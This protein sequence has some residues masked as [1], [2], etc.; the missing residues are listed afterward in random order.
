MTAATRPDLYLC[1]AYRHLL[2]AL[3]LVIAAGRPAW[4]IYL[5]D[6]CP[7]PPDLR[8]RLARAC[9][10]ARLI[11]SK[12]RTQMAAFMRLPGFVPGILRR[13][14]RPAPVWPGLIRPGRWR[15]PL[16]EGQRFAT[17]HVFHAGFFFS[18][19]VAGSCDRVVLRES[20]LNNY[21]TLPVPRGKALLRGLSGLP[22]RAQVWGEDRW[23]DR[24]EVSRP[25]DLPAPVRGKGHGFRLEDLFAALPQDRARALGTA[26]LGG[27]LPPDAAEAKGTYPTDL[28]T[29]GPDALLLTQP[30][31][32]ID[33]C[34]AA[35]KRALYAALVT[36]LRAHGYRVHVK[37]HPRERVV[38]LPD[39]RTLPAEVPIE[40]WPLASAQRFDLAVALCSASLEVGTASFARR[41]CQLVAPD[42]F[43][44]GRF[45]A[46]I[47][48]LPRRLEQRL[49]QRG[50][51][52]A[53]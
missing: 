28:S 11:C 25:E 3:A 23:I 31:E 10:E 2:V 20:G 36:V 22:A 53:L 51:G 4:V 46:L 44:P 30:L 49:S 41:R 35:E 17:G 26:F 15:A 47:P 40:A 42:Q 8:A 48:G 19:V 14:L 18:K 13:N 39:T 34:S 33:L 38:P 45:A 6:E 21:I 37:P 27:P 7:L 5:E 16:L 1:N 9:P 50:Q 32:D 12:D 29:G 43:V 52:G 24:I